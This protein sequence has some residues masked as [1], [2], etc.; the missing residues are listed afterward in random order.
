MKKDIL[1]MINGDKF[2]T[3]VSSD[4]KPFIQFSDEVCFD[5]DTRGKSVRDGNPIKT[6]FN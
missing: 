3:T 6:F 4:A 5:K 1:K 2:D